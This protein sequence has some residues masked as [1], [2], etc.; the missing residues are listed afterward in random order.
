MGLE[1]PFNNFAEAVLNIPLT[2]IYRPVSYM[3]PAF[4]WFFLEAMKEDNL[5]FESDLHIRHISCPIA[6]PHAQDDNTVPIS[7]AHK[8]PIYPSIR[9]FLA[10]L[11]SQAIN[12]GTMYD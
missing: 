9:H 1:S 5:T 12:I 6:I 11:R 4:H 3:L 2:Y 10:P 7:L 8:V